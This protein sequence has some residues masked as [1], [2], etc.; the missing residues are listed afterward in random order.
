MM[1]LFVVLYFVEAFVSMLE[2]NID[3][4]KEEDTKDSKTTKRNE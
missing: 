4:S 3:R 1:D 2:D